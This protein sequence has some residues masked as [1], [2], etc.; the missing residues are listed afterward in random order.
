[1]LLNVYIYSDYYLLK[2]NWKKTYLGN[3]NTSEILISGLLFLLLQFLVLWITLN[4]NILLESK[5]YWD[6]LSLKS[7]S[8]QSF[9]NSEFGVPCFCLPCQFILYIIYLISWGLKKILAKVCLYLWPGAGVQ[10]LSLMSILHR[11]DP[12][13][14]CGPVSTLTVSSKCWHF[15]K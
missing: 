3:R 1:M 13:K 15:L 2:M 7:N 10:A 6:D 9:Q 12:E 5:F 11:N 4:H 14:R 8:F